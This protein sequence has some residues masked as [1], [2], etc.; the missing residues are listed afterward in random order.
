MLA[1]NQVIVAQ[2]HVCLYDKVFGRIHEMG[3][4]GILKNIFLDLQVDDSE[5]KAQKF[6][7]RVGS[8]QSVLNKTC[9]DHEG[10][11]SRRGAT[12]LLSSLL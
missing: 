1:D 10:G 8:S 12:R 5:I 4:R 3:I 6:Q 2:D 7:I 9:T 11:C